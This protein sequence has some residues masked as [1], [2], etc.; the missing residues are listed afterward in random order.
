MRIELTRAIL[1]P[2]QIFWEIRRSI[3]HVFIF[4]NMFAESYGFVVVPIIKSN[5]FVS[6]YYFDRDNIGKRILDTTCNRHSNETVTLRE[7]VITY[8]NMRK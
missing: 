8:K 3:S 2:R 5:N 4:G 7:H 1:M 6:L